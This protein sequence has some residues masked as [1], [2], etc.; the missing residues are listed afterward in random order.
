ML[1]SDLSRYINWLVSIRRYIKISQLLRYMTK[2]LYPLLNPLLKLLYK[3]RFER[4]Y[5]ICLKMP[6]HMNP[7]WMIKVG[8]NDGITGDPFSRLLTGDERWHALLIEPVP[9]CVERLR[10]NFNDPSRFVIEEVAIGLSTG[11][12]MFYYVDPKAKIAMPDLPSHF[13]QLGSFS[14][15]HISKH[16]N[17]CLEPYILSRPIKSCELSAVLDI[18]GIVHP[19]L[20]HVD[21]E[22]SDLDIIKSLDFTRHTPRLIFAE[23][24]HLTREQRK[25][26]FHV[27]KEAGYFVSR[28]AGDCIAI[29]KDLPKALVCTTSSGARKGLGA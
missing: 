13:D 4:F 14:R 22:G 9:Y 28:C 17:G 5:F 27:L 26:L 10:E 19:A 1:T 8:A 3:K 11:E 20:L 24:K 12:N 21:A 2:I 16:F 23:H 7:T 6:Q 15:K 29:K 18:H 25:E